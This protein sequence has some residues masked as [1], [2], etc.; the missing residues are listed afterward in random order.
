HFAR[1][2]FVKPQF[3]DTLRDY[4]NDIRDLIL[5]YSSNMGLKIDHKFCWNQKQL[6]DEECAMQV[7]QWAVNLERSIA[8][9]SWSDDELR[10]YKQQY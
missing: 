9:S 2:Y 4:A 7:A 1:D 3:T 10:N 5:A 8:M 6:T